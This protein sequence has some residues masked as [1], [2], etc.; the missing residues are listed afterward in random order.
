MAYGELIYG[1]ARYGDSESTSTLRSPPDLMKYLP[2][3]YRTSR[4]M[5]SIQA[6]IGS[7]L[8]KLWQ[9]LNETLDQFYVD[10][11]TWGLAL[12]EKE[13]GLQADPS[14]PLDWRRSVIKAKLRGVGTTTKALIQSVAAAFSGGETEVIEYPSEY[15]FVVKFIGTRGIPPNLADLTRAIEEIK[16]AHLAFSYAYTYMVWNE[17]PTYTWAQASV[18]TWDQFRVA[19]P[20]TQ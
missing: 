7:E 9:A 17:T 13:L 19:K 11:A 4:V 6:A 15:R 10:R 16:P 2:P 3:Y 5:N 8:A 12:W 20:N 18:M 1:Q 14:L